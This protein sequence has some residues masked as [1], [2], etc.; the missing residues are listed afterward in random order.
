[1]YLVESNKSQ[2]LVTSSF[3]IK[4][5]SVKVYKKLY[6][7]GA[8]S[9]TITKQEQEGPRKYGTAGESGIIIA[10]FLYRPGRSSV[11]T[12]S[13]VTSSVKSSNT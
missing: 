3:D 7:M 10:T 6:T 9:S 12:E 8:T 11:S 13:R 2:K 1:M 4:K 5:L